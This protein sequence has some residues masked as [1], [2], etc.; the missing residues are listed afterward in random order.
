MV[1]LVPSYL[2]PT[3]LSI[4]M[5]GD[6]LSTSGNLESQLVNLESVSALIIEQFK[7]IRKLE[8]LW[9]VSQLVV[10]QWVSK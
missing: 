10:I 3:S 5:G 4:R 8:S 6:S 2:N 7:K 1:L 9:A